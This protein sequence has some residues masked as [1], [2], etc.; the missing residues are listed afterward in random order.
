MSLTILSSHK[1]VPPIPPSRR[2]NPIRQNVLPPFDESFPPDRIVHTVLPPEFIRPTKY[3]RL[4]HMG[5]FGGLC[6][7]EDPPYVDG[8]NTTPINMMMSFFLPYYKQFG[9]KW[10]DLYLKTAAEHDYSHIHLDRFN[11]E[12]AGFS[13]N[14][15]LDFFNYLI[16]WGFYVSYWATGSQDNRPNWDIVGPMCEPLVRSILNSS[17]LTERL[18][19]LP[20]EELNNGVP[21]GDLGLD[22]ILD[23]FTK[24]CNPSSLPLY[25][26][27]TGNVRA[28]W[29]DQNQTESGWAQ[30]W[31]PKMQ[32]QY[33]QGDFDNPAGVMGGHFWDSRNF[34][35]NIKSNFDVIAFELLAEGQLYGRFTEDYGCLRG[36]EMLCCTIA[37]GSPAKQVMGFGNGGRMPD[38]SSIRIS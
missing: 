33:W 31:A 12:K 29:N 28:W 7:P 9:M 19:I 27:F 1:K 21:P 34:W 11:W 32:G 10:I 8:A 26:H 22:S 35:A 14:D 16:S 24:L 3:D 23:G 37:E 17:L 18:I 15:I 13:N 30:M 5:D 2:P 25:F 36:Y 6:I 38:G 4:F 20:G